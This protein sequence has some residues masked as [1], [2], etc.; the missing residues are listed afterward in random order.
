MFFVRKLWK[1]NVSSK[2]MDLFYSS[3][4]QSVFSFAV[5]C[6]YG[7]STVESKSKIARIIKK[8][9]RLNINNIKPLLEIYKRAVVQRCNVII[10]D[11]SHPLHSCYD[12]LPSGNRWR[13]VQSRT[14]RYRESY[15]PASI[16]LLNSL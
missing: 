2:I 3:V 5:C 14:S 15:V 16:R 6:W 7:N 8:C 12:M 9:S 10:K 1:M 4:V 11:P 13:S